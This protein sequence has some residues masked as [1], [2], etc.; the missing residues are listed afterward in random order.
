MILQKRKKDF[1]GLRFSETEILGGL[2][3]GET[4]ILHP[5][6]QITDGKKIVPD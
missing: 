6:N 1:G 5:S 3:E 2:I 4:V